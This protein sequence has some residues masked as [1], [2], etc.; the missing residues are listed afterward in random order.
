MANSWNCLFWSAR[1]PP[2][3]GHFRSKPINHASKVKYPTVIGFCLCVSNQGAGVD[4]LV[5]LVDQLLIKLFNNWMYPFHGW[6]CYLS[7][8]FKNYLVKQQNHSSCSYRIIL[9]P[10]MSTIILCGLHQSGRVLGKVLGAR[11]SAVTC[12]GASEAH[13]RVNCLTRLQWYPVV[14][15][16]YFLFKNQKPP[17]EVTWL[18]KW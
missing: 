12:P 7:S 3:N 13:I 1:R 4:H 18:Y 2:K 16:Y 10:F 11:C 9:W 15:H 17:A 14:A 6:K 8:I 5:N